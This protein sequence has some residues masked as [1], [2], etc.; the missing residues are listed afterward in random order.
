MTGTASLP[1]QEGETATE[2]LI[3]LDVNFLPH[4]SVL[5]L[6]QVGHLPNAVV[7]LLKVEGLNNEGEERGQHT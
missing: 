6:F 5:R 7:E 4:T 3:R 2:D 1:G